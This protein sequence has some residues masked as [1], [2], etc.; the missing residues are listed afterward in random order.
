MILA[1]WKL[2]GAERS[3]F[4]TEDKTSSA[5]L[6]FCRLDEWKKGWS[7]SGWQLSRCFILS[8]QAATPYQPSVSDRRSVIHM[9]HSAL[10]GHG[11]LCHS[12]HQL[13]H[14]QTL[15]LRVAD[16][17]SRDQSSCSV[18]CV[19]IGTALW[20]LLLLF[21]VTIKKEIQKISPGRFPR[22]YTPKISSLP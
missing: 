22:Q 5:A 6:S 20:R 17:W 21:T 15:Q 12:C 2:K 18:A 8:R 13:W 9:S 10:T 1:P 16:T 3:V 4:P 7:N 14:L 19:L 11:P